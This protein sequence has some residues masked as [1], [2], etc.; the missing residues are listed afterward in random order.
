MPEK[1]IPVSRGDSDKCVILI[2]MAG[3]GKTTIGAALARQLGCAALDTDHLIEAA[4]GLRLQI[5]TDTLSHDDFLDTEQRIILSLRA[6]RAVISTGGSVIYRDRSMRHL[7][8]LGTVVCLDVPLS[9]ILKRIAMHPE[10]GLIIR[11]GQT[12]A[13]LYAERMSLYDRYADLHCDGTL[14]P[15][16]CARW[17]AGH[18]PWHMSGKRRRA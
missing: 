12:V 10:R 1:F 5:I 2:G 8:S 7:R 13:D 3:S 14:S 11:P 15:E 6:S 9:V 4:Y 18:L 16:G 17:I